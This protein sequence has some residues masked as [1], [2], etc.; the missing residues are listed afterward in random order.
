MPPPP[1]PPP[2]TPPVPAGPHTFAVQ[3]LGAR[4]SA[5]VV[6][7]VRQAPLAPH[8]YGLHDT[9]SPIRHTPAPLQVRVGV[10]IAPVHTAGAHTVAPA[11]KRHAPAPSQVPSVP[12]V[13]PPW[14]L[15]WSSGSVPLAA[16]MHCPSLPAIAHDLQV[17]VH[18]VAQQTFCAQIV[19]AHSLPAV[20]AAPGGFGPQLPATHAAPA[21]QSAAVAH[22]ARH[23]PSLPHRYWPHDWVVPAP[24]SPCPSHSAACVTVEPAHACAP[25]ITPVAY[26]AHAPVPSQVP[27]RMQPAM[28]SSGHSLR[29]SVP[30][31]AFMHVPDAAG[32]RARLAQAGALRSA[33]D[34][35][36]AEAALAVGVAGARLGNLAARCD[37]RVRA[38]AAAV[39][40]RDVHAVRRVVVIAGL[41]TSASSPGA[42]P[43]PGAR[44]SPAPPQPAASSA[45]SSAPRRTTTVPAPKNSR[46]SGMRQLRGWVSGA[47][48]HGPRLAV[49]LAHLG[50]LEGF[51]TSR[52]ELRPAKPVYAR[53]AC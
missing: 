9:G 27:S 30:T 14:S 17:P 51:R 50:T 41:S 36:E 8:A 21:T 4:Q 19:D 28:P 20:Q 13:A 32:Q 53:R 10:A 34:A 52:D 18:A 47:P 39:V 38:G 23:L 45:H 40:I 24:H 42:E 3:T 16:L 25:Q 44:A 37:G 7:L 15:H 31:D 33:A 46:D 49:F 5:S 2:P 12:Q 11:W 43:S 26:M 48:S 22:V 29:G 1:A 6:Q 35:V